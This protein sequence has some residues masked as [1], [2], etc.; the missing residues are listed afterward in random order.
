MDISAG[1]TQARRRRLFA[2]RRIVPAH[3]S[4]SA[5][6]SMSIPT[7]A[8]GRPPGARRSSI[9]SRR[10][11]A[12][13]IKTVP[14]VSVRQ[15]QGRG[16]DRQLRM[17]RDAISATA[18]TRRPCTKACS[19][20]STERPPRPS[21]CRRSSCATSASSA[22]RS[23]PTSS[24]A[25]T[26]FRTAA[27]RTG[28]DF[29][30]VKKFPGP[31]CLFDRSFTCLAFALLADGVPRTSSIRWI[32]TAPSARWMRSSRTSKCGGATA[33]SRSSSSATA[34]ST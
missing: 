27:R 8:S 13:A 30:N 32:S 20:R 10:R 24:T 12:F 33:R 29:W 17:G 2:A 7:A 11:P 18:S 14:G 23:A 9:R 16:A 34:K 28:R 31:R 26:N 25:R 21:N 22:I 4:Q 3:A 19:R 1:N 5:R 15:A 6:P